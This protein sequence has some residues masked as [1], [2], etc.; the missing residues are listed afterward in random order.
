MKWDAQRR[1]RI[2]VLLL[3]LLLIVNADLRVL[4]LAVDAI[5]LD[6]LLILLTLQMRLGWRGIAT[7]LVAWCSKLATAASVLPALA[8]RL[9]GILMPGYRTTLAARQILLDCARIPELAPHYRVAIA[10]MIAVGIG[11]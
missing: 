2:A 9:F 3:V 4:V 6:A 5:G 11:A 8:V 7:W 10:L 1:A